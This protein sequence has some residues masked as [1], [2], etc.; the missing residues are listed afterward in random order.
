[1]VFF[2]TPSFC[3]L[4]TYF[5]I[6]LDNVVFLILWF[7]RFAFDFTAI[8]SFLFTEPSLTHSHKPAYWFDYLFPPANPLKLYLKDIQ[9]HSY[10]EQHKFVYFYGAEVGT[11]IA[12]TQISVNSL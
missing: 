10:K 6:Y 2:H 12:C 7:E 1:M 11:F 8:L 4:K 3:S 5:P 9:G